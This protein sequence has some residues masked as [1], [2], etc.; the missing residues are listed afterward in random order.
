[1]AQYLCH[2]FAILSVSMT[3]IV[4]TTSMTIMTRRIRIITEQLNAQMLSQLN[5]CDTHSQKHM[6]RQVVKVR[7]KTVKRM[8]YITLVIVIVAVF[9][10]LFTCYKYFFYSGDCCPLNV[11]SI[12]ANST[13]NLIGLGTDFMFWLVPVMVFFWPTKS[14]LREEHTYR[15]A[16]KR[17]SIYSSTVGS[18][19]GI[20]SY[21]DSNST[22]S[23]DEDDSYGSQA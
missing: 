22:S 8:Q 2:S 15:K 12:E 4:L 10:F 23:S 3:W 19:S 18:K 9:L 1:M 14:L 13:L 6:L 21:S 5:V 16:K 7:T 17:W 20:Q 11:L